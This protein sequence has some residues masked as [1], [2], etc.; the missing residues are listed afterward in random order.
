[1]RKIISFCG[2]YLQKY[3]WRIIVL[4]LLFITVSLA[5][6]LLSYITGCFVDALIT[7]E[8]VKKLEGFI[9]S[10]AVLALVEFV[11]SYI[12]ERLYIIIQCRSGH[13]LNTDAI[14]HIQNLPYSC[15]FLHHSAA[16]Y[17][18][19]RIDASSPPCPHYI[20]GALARCGNVLR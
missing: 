7:A 20:H 2:P 8:A 1:M 13:A 3:R 6:V 9:A 16:E 19:K 10:I 4:V 17:H 12:C 5:S 18:F 11:L 15:D 14:H